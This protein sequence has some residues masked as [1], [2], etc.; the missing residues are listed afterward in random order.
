MNREL[1]RTY[2]GLTELDNAQFLDLVAAGEKDFSHCFIPEA[3]K[4]ENVSFDSCDFTGSYISDMTAINCEF[5]N[6]TFVQA[7]VYGYFKG[8]TFQNSH[9]TDS[10]LAMRIDGCSLLECT[11][12]RARWKNGYMRTSN[13]NSLELTDAVFDGTWAK[14]CTIEVPCKGRPDYT[15]GGATRDEVENAKIKFF[16]ELRLGAAV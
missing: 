3:G 7:S 9:F 14:D 11:F 2:H 13:I 16:T 8:C 1:Y 12:I 6:T 10:H 5:R 15:Q 4:L